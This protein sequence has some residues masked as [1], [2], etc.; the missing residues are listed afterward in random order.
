MTAR[1][2]L[3]LLV[4]ALLA[5]CAAACNPMQADWGF[6][7]IRN[8]PTPPD[9]PL[10]CGATIPPAGMASERSACA[11]GEGAHATQTLGV[12]PGVL[13]SIPIR[14]V[15]VLMRE[16]RSFDHLYGRLHDQGQPGVEPIPAT[17]SNP[18]LNGNA[19]YPSHADTTCIPANPGHQSAEMLAGIDGGRMDGFVQSAAR[20]TATDGHF[21]MAYNEATDLP[22]YYWLASTFALGDRH[23]APIATGTFANRNF[24]YFGTNAGVIDTGI[25]FPP[26][27]TPSIWQ[28]L[29]NAGFTWGAY[30]DGEPLD[31]TLNW[32]TRDPG[33]HTIQEFLDALD[34]GTLPN[35]AFVDGQ[36]KE[37]D[38]HPPADLQ[39]GEAWLKKIYDHAVTSPQWPRIA[40]VVTYDEAG[41]YADHVPPEPQACRPDSHSS[42]TQMGPRV[43]LMVISPWAR[44]SYVS[45]VV[46]DHTAITRLIEALFGLPA[47]T[48]RDANA[49][50]LLD[51]FDFS[52]GR[53][54]SIPP[55][56]APGT[57]GC[58][59]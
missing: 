32:S 37:Y 54:L 9:P 15:I 25:T 56:P 39:R 31:S 28:L 46:R 14:H 7:A 43:P 16:N 34:A 30:T 12:D 22:F 10:T 40:M 57:G 58:R 27:T 33:V 11:F 19:V 8:M 36:G 42:F 51:L 49:D 48:A 41:G 6:E 38:D 23:F 26:P 1:R 18:D 4:G 17:W 44:R 29:M 20:T 21:A 13:A 53:D 55:A 24:L 5:P 47:L 35:V 3:P 52:C 59:P 2:T 50:A 45:H